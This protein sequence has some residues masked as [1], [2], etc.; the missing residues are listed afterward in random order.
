MKLLILG[1]ASND[2]L[3]MI[4]KYESPPLTHE[5][6]SCR[7][8]RATSV[9]RTQTIRLAVAGSMEAVRHL[10]RHKSAE[11]QK[12]KSPKRVNSV[13]QREYNSKKEAKGVLQKQKHES[14]KCASESMRRK[15]IKK[16][17]RL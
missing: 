5:L 16:R 6:G 3:I 11:L 8:C 10:V 9:L 7:Y 14:S 1:Q 17:F 13:S 4:I 12:Q 15:V 2:A